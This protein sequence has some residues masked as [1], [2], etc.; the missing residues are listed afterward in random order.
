MIARYSPNTSSS[1]AVQIWRDV[2]FISSYLNGDNACLLW[3]QGYDL[4]PL[5]LIGAKSL[6]FSSTQV[7]MTALISAFEYISQNA[8]V[9]E[10]K[11]YSDSLG[12][13]ALLLN[14]YWKSSLI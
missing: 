5:E 6:V 7:E 2:T 14:C 13:L 4:F 9:E 10:V 12:A 3:T 1:S 8:I 11:V